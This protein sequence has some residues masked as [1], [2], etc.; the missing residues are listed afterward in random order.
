MHRI[1]RRLGALIITL[2]LISLTSFAAFHVIPGDSAISALGTEATEEAIWELREELG[3]NDT[4]PVRYLKWINGAVR[5]DFGTSLQYKLPVGTLIKE[6]LPVT[7]WLGVLSILLILIFSIP[8]GILSVRKHEGP[9]GGGVSL[10]IHIFMAIPPFF[11]G[12]LIT[13]FFGLILKWF[14]P[15]KYVSPKENFVSFL[16]Y[17]IFPALSIAIP[18]IAMVVKFLRNSIITQLKQDYVRTAKSKGSSEGRI[19][20]RHVL[21]N[22]LI[23]VITFLGLVL[24]DVLA[25]SFIIEQVFSLPGIGRLLIGS[26]SNRDFLVVQGILL[27]VVTAVVLINFIVDMIYEKIDPRIQV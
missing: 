6:R 22:A 9:I 8:I 26:I 17:M 7:L 21:K 20:Y 1:V 3:L 13:L 4:L 23:P 2:I 12:I 10:F 5:G 27:Y 19:L 11:L 14:T 15:G 18:Q 25:G 16:T 24:A